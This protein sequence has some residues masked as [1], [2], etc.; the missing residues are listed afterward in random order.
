MR[1]HFAV[2]RVIRPGTL[3]GLGRVELDRVDDWG[4][5]L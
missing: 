1:N 3:A 4:R 5:G 2:Q